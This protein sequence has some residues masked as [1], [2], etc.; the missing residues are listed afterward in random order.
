MDLKDR[1]ESV[2]QRSI[3]KLEKKDRSPAARL[4]VLSMEHALLGP[5]KRIR[6]LKVFEAAQRCCNTSRFFALALPAALAVE[7][8]HAYSLVHDDLPC[9]DNDDFRRGKPT[10]HRKFGDAVAILTGDALLSDAFGHLALAR[11]EPA[12]QC[13]V[14]A[15]AIG[16]R[17]M[18]LGQLDDI[19]S[20]K[21]TLN[22]LQNKTGKLFECA[23]R[24]GAISVGASKS[25][26]DALALEGARFGLMFQLADDEADG[27]GGPDFANQEPV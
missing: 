27:E 18:V 9:M 4:M 20:S 11:Y 7:Y 2:L 10:I 1:F 8:V 16:S 12:R 26:E 3:R 21:K 14:L 6:P 5:G 19:V 13:A 15:E 22:T 24:L 25:T 23:F 17:G